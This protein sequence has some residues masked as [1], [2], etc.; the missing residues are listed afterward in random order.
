[1]R[2]VSYNFSECNNHSKKRQTKTI[3]K[4]EKSTLLFHL[5]LFHF[6]REIETIYAPYLPKFDS[7]LM[8]EKWTNK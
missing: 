6:N 2:E 8:L 4:T 7:L 5:F 1:M 3:K